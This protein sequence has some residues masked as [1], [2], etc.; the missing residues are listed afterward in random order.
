MIAAGALC[1]FYD[2]PSNLFLPNAD[3]IPILNQSAIFVGNAARRM[4]GASSAS[5]TY[6]QYASSPS[7][8]RLDIIFDLEVV[9]Y[10][11]DSL[12]T[13][14]TEGSKMYCAPPAWSGE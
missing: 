7:P 12:I 13:S 8:C 9:L 14:G 6:V 5:S 11:G 3:V 4:S 2:L 1:L 10:N